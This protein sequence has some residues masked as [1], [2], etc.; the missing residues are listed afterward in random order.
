[1]IVQ[2]GVSVSCEGNQ[3]K[4]LSYLKCKTNRHC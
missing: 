3:S 4:V 2:H 1:M